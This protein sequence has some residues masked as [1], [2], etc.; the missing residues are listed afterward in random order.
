MIRSFLLTA[1]ILL[2]LFAACTKDK[3]AAPPAPADT[4][5]TQP[6]V[7]DCDSSKVLYCNKVRAIINASCAV[8]GC[9]VN[10]GTGTGNF[11][12]YAGVKAKVDNG[13][14]E[15]RVF[16]FGDMPPATHPQLSTADT[17]SLRQWL[18]TGSL[19]K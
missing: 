3:K 9:H 11:A 15:Q 14:F 17:T 19:E 8:T 2:V 10:G 6:V 12:T 4:T 1:G 5:S 18:D 7:S 16:V 13:T